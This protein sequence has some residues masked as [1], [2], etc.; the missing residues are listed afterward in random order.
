MAVY[1][2]L[3]HSLPEEREIME[4]LTDLTDE[5][6]DS[7]K[8]SF[9]Q[10]YTTFIDKVKHLKIPNHFTK[11]SLEEVYMNGIM[12]EHYLLEDTNNYAQ[13]EFEI[14]FSK[15]HFNCYDFNY[16]M[17]YHYC[18]YK[19]IHNPDINKLAELTLTWLDH[20]NGKALWFHNKLNS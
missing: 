16:M 11:D 6:I 7:I 10:K 4:T 13:K 15:E 12:E 8:G 14:D 20:Y 5:F 9:P 1:K 2:D 3:V 17:N 18:I 19:N